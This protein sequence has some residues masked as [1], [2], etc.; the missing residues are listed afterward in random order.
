MPFLLPL[1]ILLG[2]LLPI[3]ALSSDGTSKQSLDTFQQPSAS[4]AIASPSRPL[5]WGDLQIIHT[6]D[7]HTWLPGHL[8]SDQP[9]PNYSGDWGDFYSFV[10]GMKD[11][12]RRRGV[13]L[14]VVDS[15]DLHDGNGFGDMDPGV[16]GCEISVNP[17][18]GDVRLCL[19]SADDRS[20]SSE[21]FKKIPYDIL[22]IGNHE[23]Y[24]T[25][26]PCFR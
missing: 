17:E 22:S 11:E 19:T 21:F 18:T 5:T 16:K 2:S 7:T 3:L 25:T 12:A 23:L 24:S 10:V 15:G 20:T 13:D 9:E 8:H 14:L 26:F 6:T 1:S 4:D